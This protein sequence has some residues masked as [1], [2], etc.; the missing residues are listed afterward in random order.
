MFFVLFQNNS[1]INIKKIT[2]NTQTHK[3]LL[4]RQLNT[5]G[6]FTLFSPDKGRQDLDL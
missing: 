1:V 4:S 5:L 3:S 2:V 6:M